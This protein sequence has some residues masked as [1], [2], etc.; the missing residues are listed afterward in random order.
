M[1]NSAK[2]VW[3]SYLCVQQ[4]EAIN[5]KFSWNFT[6]IANKSQTNFHVFILL[7]KDFDACYELIN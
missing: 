1:K 5:V 7:S 4:P 2:E 6:E 3:S